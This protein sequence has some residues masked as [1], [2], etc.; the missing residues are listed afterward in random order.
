MFPLGQH[1]VQ[2]AWMTPCSQLFRLGRFLVGFILA[3]VFV[4]LIMGTIL[5]WNPWQG[6]VTFGTFHDRRMVL[7]LGFRFHR[8]GGT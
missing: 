1:L 2:V 4:L 6:S 7:G 8:G 5:L 3:P